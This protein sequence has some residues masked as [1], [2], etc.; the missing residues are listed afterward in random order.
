MMMCDNIVSAKFLFYERESFYNSRFAAI[1][2]KEIPRSLLNGVVTFESSCFI[3][4]RK[5]KKKDYNQSSPSDKC[6]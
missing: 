5:P 1:N 3:F 4:D 2:A 6:A